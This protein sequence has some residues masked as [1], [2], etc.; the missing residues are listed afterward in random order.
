[1]KKPIIAVSFAVF[2]AITLSCLLSLMVIF[3]GGGQAGPDLHGL[4]LVQ[5][6]AIP[7]GILVIGFVT[8]V[9]VTASGV[10]GG[11]KR[12]WH[13]MPQWLVFAFMLVNSLFIAGELAVMIASQALREPVSLGE[14]VP[15]IC[16]FVSSLTVLALAAWSGDGQER[17]FAGRWAPPHDDKRE[18]PED[19]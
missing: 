17:A 13:A 12:L 11:L 19:F 8:A 15:L 6:W 9:F 16:L 2:S 18:W 7:F 1:M 10:R 4:M 3:M 5:T 14:Q